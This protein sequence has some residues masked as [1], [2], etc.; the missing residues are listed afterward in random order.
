MHFGGYKHWDH[1]NSF[2]SGMCGLVSFISFEKSS[3]KV[4]SDM[5]L[6]S[7][8]VISFCNFDK[9]HIWCILHPQL[10]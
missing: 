1:S 8:S 6:P 9:I 3:A 2:D 10:L 7:H 4:S 5:V